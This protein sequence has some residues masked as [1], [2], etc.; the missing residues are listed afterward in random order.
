MSLRGLKE[1]STHVI[2]ERMDGLKRTVPGNSRTETKV[3][4]TRKIQFFFEREAT[5]KKLKEK[6]TAM[7]RGK[8]INCVLFFVSF[9]RE[10]RDFIF[11]RL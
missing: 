5:D 1:K 6:P 3:R 9:F 7:E 11:G 4:N 2:Y 8:S 10:T